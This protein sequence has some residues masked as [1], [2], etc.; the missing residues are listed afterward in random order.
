MRCKHRL[1][2]IVK[3]EIG[4]S[5]EEQIQWRE[6]MERSFTRMDSEVHEWS[7]SVKASNCRCQLRTPQCDAVGSTA[8]VALVTQSKIVV[9]NCGDSR[10]VLCRNGVAIPL[11]TDHKVCPS[12]CP[13]I[14][15]NSNR[16]L[17]ASPCWKPF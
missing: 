15:C 16:M 17:Q 7:N 1:H 14:S 4:R 13:R 12:P 11:S 10:A 5:S 6:T 8:V 9:S 3:E 2:E